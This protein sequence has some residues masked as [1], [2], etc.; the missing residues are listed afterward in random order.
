MIYWSCLRDKFR[1]NSHQVKDQQS[2]ESIISRQNTLPEL[3]YI[4]KFWD[5][6]IIQH[7]IP[8]DLLGIFGNKDSAIE[9]TDP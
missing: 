6:N 1:L 4:F 3:L 8:S 7:Q 5:S 9:R 2:W